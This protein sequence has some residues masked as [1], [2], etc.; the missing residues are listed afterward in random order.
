MKMYDKKFI[1]LKDYSEWAAELL[2]PC[3]NPNFFQQN[4]GTNTNELNICANLES[5]IQ[6]KKPQSDMK[7]EL[8]R[9]RKIQ[10]T[11]KKFAIID[12]ATVR[13]IHNEIES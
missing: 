5:E 2:N 6:E 1:F 8:Y 7:T 13:E 10:R 12:R 9:Y 11:L 3:W 4:P